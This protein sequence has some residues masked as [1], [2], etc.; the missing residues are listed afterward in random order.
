MEIS[1]LDNRHLYSSRI[2]NTY[3]KLIKRKYS[4]INIGELLSYARMETYQVED[5]GH[6][7]TQE[8]IDLFYERLEE[9]TG[10][11]NIA[12]EAGR[13]AASPE[14]IGVMRQYILGLVGP[15]K[16]YELL[17]KA[18]PNFTKSSIYEA[19]KIRSNK[20]EITVTPIEGI[21]EK[22]YQCEN[23][24]GYIEAISLAFNYR[25]PKIEHPECFFKG[26][27]VCRYIVLWQE[28]LSAFWKKVRNYV[29][30]FLSLICLSF[31]PMSSGV[32]LSV[33]LPFS[34]FVVLLLSLYV[35]IL[36]K[37]ELNSA[38]TNLSDSADKLLEHINVNYNNALMVNEMGL[39]I[40]K[41]T[42]I[43]DILMSI[44]KVLERRLDYDRGM[45]FLASEDKT[46]LIFRAGFGYA[47]ELLGILTNTSFHLDKPES[48]GVFVVSFR[49][50]KPFL[51]N[52]IE[53]I[54]ENLSPRGLEFAKRMGSRSFICCPIIYEDVSLGILGVDNVKTKKPLV[55]S[56]INL[57]MG[58][59]PQIGI[60]IHNAR[61][62]DVK[63][64]QFKSILQV[65]AASIDARDPLTAG[66]SVKVTEYAIGICEEL[67]MP[68]DYCEVIRVASL[69][70]DYGKIGIKDDILKKNGTLNI[71]E[72][73]EIKTHV[74]KTKKIL[75]QINFEGIYTEVP[76]IVECHH[77]KIDGSGYP[78]GLKGEEIPLGARII[79]VADFFE[80]ITSKRH[81]RDAM[82]L[83]TA[84][85]LLI[86]ESDV[87]FDR[88]VIEAFICYYKKVGSGKLQTTHFTE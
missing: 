57:L 13:Y 41:H 5:E 8:Q 62:S 76:K 84:F 56:D 64:R 22:P 55:Q 71:E 12:R 9:L 86:G 68:K 48:K 82:P 85:E 61:L 58:I 27:K 35:G 40:S 44:V 63:E 10:N 52:D 49:E 36:E 26:G 33:L 15:A 19:K 39:A 18:V 88:S 79:A 25:L 80:A 59:A 46:R 7:F 34:V 4:Y 73:E 65:L 66:H 75:Q 2:V 45:I 31:Y 17:G 30:L 78:K 20:V 50:Q 81:Y 3:I 38:I 32:I 53:E 74:E 83:D 24:I 87:H 70:H 29:T 43:D 6:W 72:Y 21:S 23:R 11:K 37:R 47:D 14:T 28:S 51:I 67:G 42:D 1:K 60:S 16:A 69:L 77:E 54:K